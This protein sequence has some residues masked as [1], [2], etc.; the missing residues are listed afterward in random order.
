MTSGSRGSVEATH[1]G[2]VVE[3]IL[4]VCAGYALFSVGDALTKLVAAKYHFMQMLFIQ[5]VITMALAAAFGWAREGKKAFR[6]KKP[7]LMLARA[8]GATTVSLLNIIALPKV[9]MTTFYTVMFLSPF[10]VAVLAYFFL[11]DKMG[12]R[13]A[14]VILAGFSVVLFIFRPG[15]GLLNVWSAIV[16]ASALCYSVQLVIM[17]VIGAGES[18]AFMIMAGMATSLLIS[19]PFMPAHYVPPTMQDWLWFFLIGATSVGGLFCMIRGVQM[20]PSASV[21]APYHYTQIFWGAFFGYFIFSDVPDTQTI[22]GAVLIILLGL[23][24][25]HSERRES[26]LKAEMGA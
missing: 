8:A 7:G 11:G 2:S 1:R 10:C 20:A 25:L 17:R 3:A 23:Y 18:R 13:R 19:A 5:S 9:Q 26:A 6:T 22:A 14:A 4:F 12:R 16:L 24:L 15:G 21:V